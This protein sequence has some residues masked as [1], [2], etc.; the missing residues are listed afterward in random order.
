MAEWLTLESAWA[1]PVKQTGREAPGS[2]SRPGDHSRRLRP[3]RLGDDVDAAA[4]AVERDHAVGQREQGVVAADADVAAGVVARA[5]L[6]HD[7]SAGAH[8][9]PAVHL[10]AQPLRVGIAAVA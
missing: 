1:V 9:L 2:A 6:P 3:R 8:R 7:D 4:L 10:D 5:A